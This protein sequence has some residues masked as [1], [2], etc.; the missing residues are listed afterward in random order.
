[1][2]KEERVREAFKHKLI[3]EL[4]YPASLLISEREL[5]LLPHLVGI[6]VPKRRLDLLC[7]EKGSMKPLLLVECKAIPLS[8]GALDQ[9]MGYNHFVQASY[10]ALVNQT[11]ILTFCYTRGEYHRLERLPFYVDIEHQTP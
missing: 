10:I 9:V 3:K 7:L 11:E 5:S 6:E 2:G 4:G 8:R 1:M